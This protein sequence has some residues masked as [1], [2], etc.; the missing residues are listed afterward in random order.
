MLVKKKLKI[1]TK[2]DREEDILRV[3]HTHMHT[4]KNAQNLCTRVRPSNVGAEEE[5]GE[6]TIR[7]KDLEIWIFVL[8]RM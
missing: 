4:V 3:S 5:H 2:N 7:E 8:E 1:V 6:K